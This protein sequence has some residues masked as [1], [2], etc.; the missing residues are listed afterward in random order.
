MADPPKRIL[1]S[2]EPHYNLTIDYLETFVRK[3]TLEALRGENILFL[4]DL[5]IRTPTELLRIPDIT[6]NEVKQLQLGMM[7]WGLSLWQE[8]RNR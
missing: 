6:R 8:P 7:Y 3:R 4:R 5:A 2:N 1:I